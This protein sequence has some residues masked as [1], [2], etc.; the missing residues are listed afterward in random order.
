MHW[1][2]ARTAFRTTVLLV[3]VTRIGVR[4]PLYTIA[5]TVLPHQARTSLVRD[6]CGT[7][8]GSQLFTATDNPPRRRG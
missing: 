2:H 5:Q 8:V 3:L 6:R 4:V 1:Q 7:I